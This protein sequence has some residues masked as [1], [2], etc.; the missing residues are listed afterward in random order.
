MEEPKMRVIE[1]G[2]GRRRGQWARRG[3]AVV[4]L[5]LLTASGAKMAGAQ[6][7]YGSLTGNVTDPTGAALGGAQVT[8][9]EAQT[10]VSNTQT[11]DASGIYRF[12]ALL[13]GTY[14]VTITG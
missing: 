1:A 14:K 11:T 9:V 5:A 7:L 13:P 3:L 10:G 8:A 2:R 6:V 4:V 12:P